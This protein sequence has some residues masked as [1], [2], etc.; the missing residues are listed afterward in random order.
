MNS[1]PAHQGEGR[2]LAAGSAT[3][4]LAQALGLLALLAIVTVLARRLSLPELGVYGLV[5]TLAGYLLV[6][7][8]SVSVAAVAR[9]AA[10]REGS[11]RAELFGAA[12][13]LYGAAGLATGVLIVAVG[14]LL[15]WLVALEP[16]LAAEARRGA[17]ALALVTAV[18]LPVTVTRDAMRAA[19]LY[20]R[21]ASTEIVAVALNV[22]VVLALALGGAALWLLIGASGLLPLIGGV[23]AAP[24]ARAAR[25]LPP[26]ASFGSARERVRDLIPTAGDLFAVEVANLVIYGFDRVI[27]GVLRS[28][29]A[30]GLYEGPIRAHNLVRALNLSIAVTVVPAASRLRAAGDR[31]RLGELLVR[32]S[33]YVAGLVVPLVVTLMV[34]AAPVLDVWLGPE[35]REA[36]PAM[37]ILL[38]YW[39]LA[40]ALGFV[41]AALVGVGRSRQ[42]ARLAWAAAAANLVLSMALTPSLGLEGVAIGTALPM[43]VIFPALLTQALEPAGLAVA[44]L[45]RRAWAPA[46]ALGAALALA[47]AL[48]RLALGLDSL[49]ALLAVAGG[50]LALYWLAY[51]AL[52]LTAAERSLLA[53]LARGRRAAS[54]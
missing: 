41:T 51:L 13:L 23:V 54:A 28:A 5:S 53:G 30:V 14:L 50:G 17:L 20:T 3:Q 7:H 29:T 1:R 43:V 31:A 48:A 11:E 10:A 27:L 6:L 52:F 2:A 18:G 9:M 45:A 35:F 4:A 44:E 49:G 46:Y 32:G 39:L 37:T 21:A 40:P 16:A 47:L 34:L 33:R 12:A 25:A 15:A 19:G 26:R 8:N 24:V 36:A 42:Y 22:A 38:S